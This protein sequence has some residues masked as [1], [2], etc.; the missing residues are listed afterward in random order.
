MNDFVKIGVENIE[1][2]QFDKFEKDFS[3]IVNGKIYKTNSFVANILSPHISKIFEG[4]MDISYYQIN[5]KYEGDFNRIIEY[6]EM[7]K[8]DIKEEENLYF[9]NIMKELG[10]NNELLRLGKEFQEEIS[11]ENVIQRIQMK[12]EININIDEEI[13]YISSHFNDFQ[14]ISPEAIFTLDADIIEQ[15][16]SNDNF[17]ISKEEDLLDI[18]LQLYS[19]SKEYSI[20]FSYVIF[21]NLSTES[22]IKFSEK[23]DISDINKSIW[24]KICSRL[25]LDISN[26]SKHLYIKSHIKF[27]NDRYANR[28][29]H[30]IQ[31]LNEQCHGNAHTQNII[32]ITSSSIHGNFK[33]QNIIEQSNEYFGTDDIDNSWIQFDFKE[34]KVLLDHYTLKSGNWSNPNHYLKSWILEVSNDGQNYTEINRQE[35]CN[36]LN[37]P[38]KTGT[39]KVSCSA[40]QRY[41]RLKQIGP[42]W[43]NHNY[44]FICQIEF[45]GF[46]YE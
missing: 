26:E 21:I 12:K 41:V 11:Y 19:K 35:N 40:P 31:H 4:N 34:K 42:N 2:I 27:L 13:K 14:T 17:K 43:L 25:K 7:K 28:Y 29:E 44:L 45:S 36:L 9:K 10:N 30:I 5:P 46:L 15:I 37:G 8:I 6:G 18:I 33:V 32:H 38:L 1:R 20:L 24:E 22:I 16:I 3:F 23:F 39:F